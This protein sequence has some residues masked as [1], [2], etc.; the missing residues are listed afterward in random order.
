M[1]RCSWQ[2]QKVDTSML[3]SLQTNSRKLFVSLTLLAAFIIVTQ[4]RDA[5][6]AVDVAVN[7]WVPSIQ[8]AWATTAA[9]GIAYAFDTYSLL[10]ASLV[11]AGYLF[12]KNYRLESLVLLGAMGGDAVL[13]AG[14]KALVHFPRPINGLMVDSGYSFPSGHTVGVIVF[15]GLLAYFAWQHWKTAKPR[16]LISALTV[17]VISVV[18]FDRI[19]LNVHWF[20]DVLGGCLL[21]LFWL[22]F[23]IIL[24][25]LFTVNV[26]HRSGRFN[27]ASNILFCV[28]AFVAVGLLIVQWLPFNQW[29]P[30]ITN[31]FQSLS[32]TLTLLTAI[33]YVGLFIIVFAESG[34][35]VG[36]FLPGDSL[37]F[38]AGILASQEMFSIYG[39]VAT[40][41]AGAILGDSF[42]YAF[43]RK[44]GP[45]LV[46]RDSRFLSKNRIESVQGFFDRHGSKTI[47]IAR[48][49]PVARTFAP[50]IA[51]A[52][53][54]K[55]RL[56]LAYNLIGGLLWG[57]ALPLI[58]FLAGKAIAEIDLY[59]YPIITVIVLISLL[60]WVIGML[61]KRLG[62]RTLSSKV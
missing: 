22:T 21:G 39:V 40:V 11:I 6:S 48:F 23:A 58:G 36:F 50:I 5:F 33:G 62:R 25:K 52:S 31:L 41:V 8:L 56:F 38:T 44:V 45:M 15:C 13:V 35:F 7:V 55:Y 18:G 60:P 2:L 9:I 37:L 51:G 4:F 59:I 46:K 27:L 57:I 53:K 43:G 24:Y 12:Y 14:T 17:T 47:L 34:L 28:A 3:A 19:Y 26:K 30:A 61:V 20:S 29:L 54:M 32:N 49:V 42:G 16:I 1:Y 10:I